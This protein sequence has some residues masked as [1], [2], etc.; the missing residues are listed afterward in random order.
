M[1]SVLNDL[2]KN[3]NSNTDNQNRV[4]EKIEEI[5]NQKFDTS[6]IDKGNDFNFTLDN[7]IYT[8]TSTSNQKNNENKDVSTID[9]G[10]CETEPKTNIKYLKMIVYI[11]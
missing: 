10:Q 3:D 2:V 7:I 1:T 6:Y 4:L 5:F 11:Y 9:L 8:I